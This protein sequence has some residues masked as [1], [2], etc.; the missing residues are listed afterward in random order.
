[1][2]VAPRP[3]ATIGSAIVQNV[4]APRRA[5]EPRRLEDRARHRVEEVLQHPDGERHLHRGVDENQPG[6][7]SIRPSRSIDAVDRHQQDDRRQ[8]LHRQQR[9]QQRP[10]AAEALA[11]QHVRG[12]NAPPRASAA[13]ASTATIDAV[14]EI[15]RHLR[16][17]SA[18]SGSCA[19]DRIVRNPP[20]R[21]LVDAGLALQ[22][23]REQPQLRQQERRRATAS[24]PDGP[25][26]AT[27]RDSLVAR[28]DHPATASARRRLGRAMISA[29][30][31]P[32]Q[33][34]G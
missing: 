21:V 32:R 12:R 6:G 33:R 25:A 7:V 28:S 9:R 11:R 27:P 15:P 20:R 13:V 16:V 22:R 31:D 17:R 3:G 24:A 19:S 5:V 18:R 30:G 4:R 2:A 26:A 34:A 1:M 23:Q 29:A 8:H 10:A 14:P